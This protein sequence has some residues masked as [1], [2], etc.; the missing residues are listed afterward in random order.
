MKNTISMANKTDKQLLALVKNGQRA[1]FETAKAIWEIDKRNMWQASAKSMAEF[2]ENEFGM[3]PAD[4]SRYKGA[5]R[6][7]IHLAE[8]SVLPTNEGQA[9]ELANSSQLVSSPCSSALIHEAI[10]L[11]SSSSWRES[12][13]LMPLV[14]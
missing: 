10:I 9:R 4:V 11:H 5:A 14:S 7:L 3:S 6:V 8:F 12:N 1:F 2:C 13:A